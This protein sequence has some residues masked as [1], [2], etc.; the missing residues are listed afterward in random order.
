MELKDTDVIR[1]YVVWISFVV[2]VFTVAGA[3][4]VLLYPRLSGM[5]PTAIVSY[6]H[7]SRC[8]HRNRDS[9]DSYLL[10]GSWLCW[11]P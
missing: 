11:W 2:V 4:N 1:M 5:D 7:W 9:T 8:V 6:M 10:F 3:L